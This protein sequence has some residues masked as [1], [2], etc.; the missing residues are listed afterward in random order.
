MIGFNENFVRK[1]LD[2]GISERNLMIAL[3]RARGVTLK[4]IADDEGV[5]PERIR[6]IE[7]KVLRKI[8][9]LKGN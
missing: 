1:C 9:N 2:N 4:A 8:K 3:D 7:A 6:Q 5:T